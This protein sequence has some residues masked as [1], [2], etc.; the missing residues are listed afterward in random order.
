[1]FVLIITSII[2]N[3][4]SHNQ[5]FNQNTKAKILCHFGLIEG[6]NGQIDVFSTFRR[7]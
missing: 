2:N 6:L 5:I 3:A 1:M 4:H 7:N